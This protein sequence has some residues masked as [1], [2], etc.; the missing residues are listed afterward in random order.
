MTVFNCSLCKYS[1]EI[2]SNYHK[3]LKT[4]KHRKR[5]LENENMFYKNTKIYNLTKND[6]KMVNKT[7]QKKYQCENCNK[8]YTSKAH[9]NRHIKEYCKEKDNQEQLLNII[10]KQNKAIV[11]MHLKHEEEKKI[12]FEK[13]DKLLDHVGDTTNNITNNK[14]ILNC[15]GSEDY[16]HITDAFKNMLI[17]LPYTMIPKF[18]EELHF[19]KPE[20]NNICLPNKKFPLVKVFSDNRWIYK[21][22]KT[23]IKELIDKNLSY[24]DSYYSQ[25]GYEHMNDNQNKRYIEFQDKLKNSE[26]RTPENVAKET[27]LILLSHE[28]K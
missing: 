11:E 22:K 5:V 26:D 10:E 3:H 1:T 19:S 4:Q 23:T 13:M 28:I 17:K 16:S 27:E 8:F 21:D 25:T 2:N 14:I 12:L 18:I 7:I 15:Y 6:Q 20:N 9:L 24:L